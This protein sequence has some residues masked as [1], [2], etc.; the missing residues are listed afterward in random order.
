MW[1]F[2]AKNVYRHLFSKTKNVQHYASRIIRQSLG[3]V[4]RSHSL[5]LQSSNYEFPRGVEVEFLN[6]RENCS[7]KDS[8]H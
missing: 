1:A 7:C 2:G 5:S 6:E 8:H 3:V 4:I